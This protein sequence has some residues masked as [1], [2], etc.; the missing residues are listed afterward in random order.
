MLKGTQT[1]YGK[2]AEKDILYHEVIPA[3]FFDYAKG[4]AVDYT[5]KNTVKNEKTGVPSI[6]EYVQP[7][8]SV[9]KD[10]KTEPVLSATDNDSLM[11]QM[12]EFL[13]SEFPKVGALKKILHYCT[14][15]YNAEYKES[16]RPTKDLDESAAIEKLAA[17]LVK[18]GTPKEMATQLAKSAVEQGKAAKAAA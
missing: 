17:T 14:L 13:D 1:M 15:Q 5:L 6:K 12:I 3:V 4:D 18:M 2:N 7:V 8:E 9:V 11:A 10:G 16:K